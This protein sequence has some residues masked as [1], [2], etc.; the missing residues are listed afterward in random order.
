MP[1]NNRNWSPEDEKRLMDMLAGGAT[2][3]EIANAL[4]RTEAAVSV[5]ASAIRNRAE[6]A[7][8]SK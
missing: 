8:I 5:R 1:R 4:R 6:I 7:Q 2:M 3:P